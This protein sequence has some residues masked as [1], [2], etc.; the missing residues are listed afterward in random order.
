[1]DRTPFTDDIDGPEVIYTDDFDAADYT[2]DKMLGRLWDTYGDTRTAH[3]TTDATDAAIIKA[4]RMA[5]GFVDTFATD[6]LRYRVV[7]DAAVGTAGTSYAERKVIISPEPLADRTI[8]PDEANV[9]LTAMSVH[10]VSHVRYGKNTSAAVRKTWP[11]DDAA[12]ALSNILDDHRIEQRFASDYPGYAGVFAPALAYVG[13]KSTGGKVLPADRL[14]GVNVASAAVRYPAHIDWTDAE[15]E[16]D[17]W[18]SWAD[19][20]S[21]TDKVTDHVAGVREAIE[22]LAIP[23][24]PKGNGGDQP[25]DEPG[26]DKG[27]PGGQPGRDG[28]QGGT[29]VEMPGGCSNDAAGRG[30]GID[31][32]DAQDLIERAENYVETEYG[33]GEVILHP[34]RRQRAALYRGGIDAAAAAIRSTFARSRTGHTAEVKPLKRGSVDNR[35]LARLAFGDS[36]VCHRRTAPSVGAYRVWLMVDCSGSMDGRE[37]YDAANVA[38]ALAEAS[39]HLPTVTLEVFGWNSRGGAAFTVER[40]YGPG[41]DVAGIAALP[42]MVGGGTPDSASLSWAVGA[43]RRASQ[44]DE[45]PIV[46]MA[47]DGC[48]AA[49][50][51]MRGIVDDARRHGVEVVSVAL[52]AIG[53]KYQQEVYGD[54]YI[55]WAGSIAATARPLARLIGRLISPR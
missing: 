26:D 32:R 3:V 34:R 35:S 28:G 24:P 8:T 44:R 19:R 52:G 48:G 47:S 22:H 4:H 14:E 20:W 40:V 21:R 12:A 17:W 42:R 45:T 1:M 39:R 7:F 37:V 11:G 25:G 38:T 16:R 6:K 5:Q 13:R 15:A 46:L 27:Q 29:P 9:I 54:R 50:A 43:I 23:T 49:A 10:E 33:M 31:P 53:E 41:A 55:P 2:A 18:Q 51:T 36:R 30:Q